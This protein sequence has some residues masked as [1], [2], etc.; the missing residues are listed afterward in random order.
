MISD[1]KLINIYGEPG[2][3]QVYCLLPYKMK[4]A[5]NEKVS[6]SRFSCHK[7]IKYKVE[8][9]FKEVLNHYGLEK[10]QKMGLDLFGGCLNIRNKIGGDTLSLHSWGLAIDL[11]PEHNQ[12]K[13]GK[14]KARFAHNDYKDF[15]N[16]VE[17][18]GGY[19]MGRA[20][21]YDWM[22]FQFLPIN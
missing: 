19:S 4:L 21:N 9:T 6:I 14:D 2:S 1:E 10:V 11:D 16:I 12:L 7:D 8:S 15:W 20:K 5:W 18:F 3:N 17:L 22:H 13:W